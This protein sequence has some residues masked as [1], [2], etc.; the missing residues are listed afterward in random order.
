MMQ[1]Q[2]TEPPSWLTPPLFMI[3]QD[4]QGNWVAQDLSGVRGGLFVN[5]DAAL[6][7][8]RSE[9]GDRPQAVIMVSGILEL[10]MT[11]KPAATPRRHL[12]IDSERP[13]RVA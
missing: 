5:R 1:T 8:V 12:I 7:F 9:N 4:G 6:R 10:D 13:R 11:R 2:E 3:G